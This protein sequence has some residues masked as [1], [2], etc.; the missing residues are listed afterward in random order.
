MTKTINYKGHEVRIFK[1]SERVNSV[2][3]SRIETYWDARVGERVIGC[4][5]TTK[6]EAL[7]MALKFADRI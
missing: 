7:Q 1:V 3:G 2:N 4:G 6:N 5:A